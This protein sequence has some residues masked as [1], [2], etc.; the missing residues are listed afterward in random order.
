MQRTRK[1]A[2]AFSSYITEDCLKLIEYLAAREEITRIVFVRRAVKHFLQGDK[3]IDPRILIT[4]RKS[5]GYIRR[6]ALFTGYIDKEQKKI[7]TEIA[8]SQGANF[9]QVFFQ[10]M[11]NYCA[12][13]ITIDNTGIEI[14]KK[15]N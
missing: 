12:L 10:C 7:L 14:Y 3:I 1:N 4:A 9:S 13:L 15:P 5:K 2:V 6:D 8:H 11:I